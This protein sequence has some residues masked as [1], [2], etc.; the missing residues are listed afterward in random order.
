MEK[1]K[2]KFYLSLINYLFI[3]QFSWLKNIYIRIR[4]CRKKI[5]R[6]MFIDINEF[7]INSVKDIQQKKF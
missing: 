5:Q 1:E 6:N 2:C 7:I 4:D 3:F